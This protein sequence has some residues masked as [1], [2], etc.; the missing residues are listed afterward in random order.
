MEWYSVIKRNG[1]VSFAEIWMDL[2]TGKQ[3]EVS[4]KKKK[5]F[6]II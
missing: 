4:Q 3:S 5:K 6:H 2:E 1:I